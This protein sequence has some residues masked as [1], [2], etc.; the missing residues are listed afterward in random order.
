MFLLWLRQLPWCEAW[1]PASVPPPDEGRSRPTNTPVSPPSSSHGSFILPSFVWAC[2]LLPWSGTPVHSRL[3]FCLHLCVWRCIPDVSMERDVFHVHLLLCH[4]SLLF[5]ILFYTSYYILF[6]YGH[7]WRWSRLIFREKYGV[8][9]FIFPRVIIT[10][11]WLK[12]VISK[13]LIKYLVP[14]ITC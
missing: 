5:S 1:T 6:Y 11:L 13:E 7:L 8:M 9:S 4:L 3:V 10:F 14:Q 12:C 2:I